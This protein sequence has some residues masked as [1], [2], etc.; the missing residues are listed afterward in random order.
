MLARHFNVV[1]VRG[2]NGE[3]RL[4]RAT[5]TYLSMHYLTTITLYAK[6]VI[7]Y[8]HLVRSGE[9]FDE[10]SEAEAEELLRRSFESIAPIWN[11]AVKAAPIPLSAPSTSDQ[12]VLVFYPFHS[13]D[14]K[15]T[16]RTDHL[17]RH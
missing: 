15:E 1:I 2:C 11:A 12:A 7:G 17:V 13:P 5:F 3:A 6:K 4:S 8:G 10:I 14:R 9:F 16:L